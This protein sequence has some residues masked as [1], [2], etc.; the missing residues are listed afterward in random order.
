MRHL[1]PGDEFTVQMDGMVC[2]Y[3]YLGNVENG[4]D[5]THK[6]RE[7][8]RVRKNGKLAG[9]NHGPFYVNRDWLRFNRY[10]VKGSSDGEE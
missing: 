9:Y 4:S 10:T 3:I 8:K 7:R 6:V 2:H 1:E 5:L